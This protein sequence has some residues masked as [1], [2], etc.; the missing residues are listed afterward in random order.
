MSQFEPGKLVNL[1][2]LAHRVVAPNAGMMTGPGTNTYLVGNSELAVIDPG[3]NI[4]AHI[5]AILAAAE[6][7]NGTIKWILC[8]H[9]HPDHSPA[10][11]AL[12]QKT[13]AKTFGQQAP[14][15]G[16]SQDK[17]FQPDHTWQD[18]EILESDSF[19]LKAIYTPGHASNHWCYL[20]EDEQLLFTGDHIME[21]ST[22]VI[23]PPDG[24]M[25]HYIESL[26]KLKSEDLNHI[27]PGHGDLI[28]NPQD[29]VEGTIQHR[30]MR[31][32]KT[33]EKLSAIQPANLD[34]LVKDVYDEVPIFL[35]SLAKL[36]LTAHL[37]KLLVEGK[38]SVDNDQWTIS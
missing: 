32:T 38:V 15:V 3:P 37:N 22:V 16:M 20:L 35:H 8:T 9:T 27:A 7:L 28:S 6:S 2:R 11:V 26:E 21:G 10:T 36:S 18:H 12:Q 31:E 30:L 1:S 29:V 19:R 24:D 23:S 4:D 34:E 25:K 13:G 14:T 5:D 33:L 17:S